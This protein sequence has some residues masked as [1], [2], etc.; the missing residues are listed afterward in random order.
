MAVACVRTKP[1]RTGAMKSKLRAENL[2]FAKDQEQNADADPQNC[3]GARV[4]RV[5]AKIRG[6]RV[7]SASV[8][9]TRSKDAPAA[10]K[11]EVLPEAAAPRVFF[12]GSVGRRPAFPSGAKRPSRQSDACDTRRRV[13]HGNTS[14]IWE[15][16]HARL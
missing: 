9:I 1:R 14:R 3:K 5:G 16:N 8:N 10:G 13:P 2:V 11:R 15:P 7:S 6:H 4:T 12:A